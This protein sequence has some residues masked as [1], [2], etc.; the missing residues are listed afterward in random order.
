MLTN[1]TA[2]GT[3]NSL[4]N[5]FRTFHKNHVTTAARLVRASMV[6]ADR[7]RIGVALQREPG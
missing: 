5:V 6:E 7:T 2:V 1:F 4:S 3:Q